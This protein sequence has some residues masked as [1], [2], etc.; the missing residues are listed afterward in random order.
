LNL[1]VKALTCLSNVQPRSARESTLEIRYKCTSVALSCGG[2]RVI[3]SRGFLCLLL[4]STLILCIVADSPPGRSAAMDQG[5]QQLQA[6][7]LDYD[8]MSDPFFHIAL[9][10]PENGASTMDNMPDFSF[11]V[12]HSSQTTFS[13]SL[14]LENATYSAVYASESDVAN[15]SIATLTPATPIPNGG[16]SWWINCTDGDTSVVGE[17]RT[18][19]ISTFRG[20]KTFTSTLDASVRTYWLDLPD[21]FDNLSPTPL[22]VFLHGYGGSRLS[23]PQK[24]PSLRQTFQSNT[25]I[26]AAVECRTVS[27]YQNWYTEPS[28]RDITDIINTVR[29]DYNIDANHIH[30]M[31]NSMGGG[32]ALKYAMF[33]NGVIASLVDIHGITNFTQFY[34]ENLNYRASLRAAYGGTPSQVPAIYAN[35]SALGNEQRF[36]HTPVMIMHGTADDVVSVSESRYLNQSLSS[37]GYTVEYIEVPGVAHDASILISGRETEILNWFKDHAL[38]VP[39]QRSLTVT[40]SGHGSTNTTGTVVYEL[41]HNVTVLATADSGYQLDHWLLNGIDAGSAN[42]FTLN[43]TGNFNL[44]AVFGLPVPLSGWQ[45]NSG[46]TDAPYVL[47]SSA[48]GLSV[49]L[50]AASTSSKVAIYTIYSPK[51]SLSDYGSV[52]V[53]VTGTDN[54]KVLLRFFLDDGSSFDVVYWGSPVV[55]DAVSFDLSSY[56]GRSLSGLVYVALM[57][58]DGSTASIDVTG[59]AFEAPSLPS[60]IVPLSGWVVNPSLTNAPYTLSSTE[61]SL[62]LELEATSTNS[63]V[64]VYTLGVSKLS[65]A[66]YGYV[67]VAVTGTGNAKVLLRFFLDDGSSFD[68]T[69]WGSPAALNAVNFDLS[70]YAG[71]TLTG[72]VYVALMSSDGSTASIDITA[73]VFEAPVPPSPLVPL[74]GWVVNPSLTNAPYVLSSAESSL[75]LELEATSTSSKVAVY[76]VGASKLSLSDYGYVD[77]SVTGSAN[78]RVLLRFFTNDGGSFDVV[79]WKDPATLDAV[80]FDLSPYAGKTLTGLVYVALM[81]SDGDAVSVTFTEI[82][83]ET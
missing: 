22:V 10:S 76:S 68:I 60:P 13:C 83:F 29:S 50:D 11:T 47:S 52:E 72:L 80:L 44:V 14:W 61:S 71:R 9:G 4:F 51:L 48:S 6:R 67:D 12:L 75:L 79:Y 54:A 3:N 32:G 36:N 16:W 41:Y 30:V 5:S 33:N 45:V 63:K 28:R 42:P 23:Y 77:V 26:V 64:A 58:S 38:F 21:N 8:M 70:S 2:R 24:Y 65:L 19:A 53:A 74:S 18:I 82:V 43:M 73:I 62:S 1:S 57:S 31:G 55:L 20:D 35:E 7:E 39:A 46:L 25:W 69:Y 40:V 34:N 15:G 56:A 27:G 49:E 59:I 81:S 78:A 37:L 17:K 66:D